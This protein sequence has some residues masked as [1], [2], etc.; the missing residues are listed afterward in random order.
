MPPAYGDRSCNVLHQDNAPPTHV[1]TIAL[2]QLGFAGSCRCQ[3]N[4]VVEY[5]PISTIGSI[6][7]RIRSLRLAILQI[8]SRNKTVPVQRRTEEHGS[9]VLQNW[10]LDRRQHQICEFD[11]FRHVLFGAASLNK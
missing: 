1:T 11:E 2:Q 9:A 7:G 8:M 3:P 4:G 5:A 10:L 6:P